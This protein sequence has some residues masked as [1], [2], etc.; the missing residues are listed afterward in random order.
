[1]SLTLVGRDGNEPCRRAGVQ[2]QVCA[3]RAAAGTL[4]AEHVRDDLPNGD[5]R[6]AFTPAKDGAA[7]QESAP[8]SAADE[9]LPY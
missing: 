3:I 1:M 2:P 9:D 6:L 8:A 7:R 4:V 5:N